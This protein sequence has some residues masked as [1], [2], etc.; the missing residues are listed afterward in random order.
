MC[1][2][3][4]QTTFTMRILHSSLSPSLFRV[5]ALFCGLLVFTHAQGQQRGRMSSCNG[6]S[7]RFG[8][9]GAFELA[10]GPA[11]LLDDGSGFGRPQ[12]NIA[13]FSR[14]RSPFKTGVRLGVV[15]LGSEVADALGSE[16]QST[17]YRSFMPELSGLLRLDPFRGRFRPFVEGELGLA[18]SVMDVRDF[19]AEGERTEHGIPGLDAGLNYGWSAGARVR[20]GGSAYLLLRY[21]SKMGT[22]LEL[23]DVESATPAASVLA[24]NRRDMSLGLS[25]GF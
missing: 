2:A 18:A 24:P 17:R 12:A 16:G 5:A 3:V 20:M 19:D 1:S 21:G 8:G 14:Q 10:V 22:A 15:G 6:C 11:L 25:L 4:H 23:H 13:F 7:G 9:A